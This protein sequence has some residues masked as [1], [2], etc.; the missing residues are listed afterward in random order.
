MNKKEFVA[1][2]AKKTGLTLSKSEEALKAMIDGIKSTLKKK[3]RLILVG[4]GTFSVKKRAARKG[5]NP[6]TGKTLN[7]PAKHVPSFKAGKELKG[8]IK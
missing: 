7:I 4:F 1:H 5:R 6:K 3:D 8:S 2:I